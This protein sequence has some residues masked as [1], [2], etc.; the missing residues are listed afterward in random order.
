MQTSKTS[1]FSYA[2]FVP[3]YWWTWRVNWSFKRFAYILASTDV[4]R[5]HPSQTFFFL[6]WLTNLFLFNL[7]RAIESDYESRKHR[8]ARVLWN[9]DA[10]G[11][12][13]APAE[14]E[15]APA[16]T[17]RGQVNAYGPPPFIIS[18]LQQLEAEKSGRQGAASCS[19]WWLVRWLWVLLL[20]ILLI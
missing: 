17:L 16:D 4:I 8:F 11:T 2:S 12:A 1:R 10:L 6:L 3:Q 14:A 15:S 5:V 18:A 9:A 13:H 19:V 7:Y 20:L